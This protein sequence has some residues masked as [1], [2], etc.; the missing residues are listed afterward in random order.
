MHAAVVKGEILESSDLP[1]RG[2]R[3]GWGAAV[4]PHGL[5]KA[6]E[7]RGEDVVKVL[8][9]SRFDLVVAEHGNIGDGQPIQDLPRLFLPGPLPPDVADDE[10]ELDL[11]CFE[12]LVDPL[13]GDRETTLV[14]HRAGDVR[15]RD[16]HEG[17]LLGRFGNVRL[18]GL[19]APRDEE[20]Q[21]GSDP[22]HGLPPR[23]LF[24]RRFSI[25]RE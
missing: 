12:I 13:D 9:T 7:R 2:R 6:S 8:L 24:M 21:D 16:D 19:T 11:L 15:V 10:H 20:Q 23:S 18:R 3:H 4:V 5:R 22:L 1:S 14:L 17:E 25:L